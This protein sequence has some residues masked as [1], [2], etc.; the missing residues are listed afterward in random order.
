MKKQGC[1]AAERENVV[2]GWGISAK[3]L[4]EAALK[5][6][7]WGTGNVRD[8]RR[9]WVSVKNGGMRAVGLSRQ[10]ASWGHLEQSI[11]PPPAG[12]QTAGAG[13][14]EQVSP[15]LIA[16]CREWDKAMPSPSLNLSGKDLATAEL[17]EGEITEHPWQLRQT[18][19]DNTSR[20]KQHNSVNAEM[21][22]HSVKKG[23]GETLASLSSQGYACYIKEKKGNQAFYFFCF[24]LLVVNGEETNTLTTERA[25]KL[26]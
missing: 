17:L 5:N 20:D 21:S 25:I 12:M 9:E 13:R 11:S 10:C 22:F 23:K 19:R 24:I 8:E 7:A 16:F 6:A 3:K 4:L 18:T 15:P 14:T 26:K 2:R 1:T